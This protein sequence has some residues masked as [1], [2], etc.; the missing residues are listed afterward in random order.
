MRAL[1]P[2]LMACA[3]ARPTVEIRSDDAQSKIPQDASPPEI[4]LP[5]T[6]T[7]LRGPIEG[8][9]AIS[10]ARAPAGLPL[11]VAF[12]VRAK[13]P[14]EF[15]VGGDYRGGPWSLRHQIVVADEKGT[16]LFDAKKTPPL[17]LGGLMGP[18]KLAVDEER[19]EHFSVNSATDVLL[20]PGRYRV[21][22]VRRLTRQHLGAPAGPSGCDDLLPS[23]DTSTEKPACRAWLD[24]FPQI[25]SDVFIEITPYDREAIL[26]DIE[27]TIAT[28][29]DAGWDEMRNVRLGWFQWACRRLSCSCPALPDPMHP[30]DFMRE[31]AKSLPASAPA[32]PCKSATL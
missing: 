17:F 23:E 5:K 30:A 19:K 26:R 1:L 10:P 3:C 22:F 6:V 11:V 21:T 16:V 18:N 24:S 25:A 12:R 2:L 15:D 8:E 20:T 32:K 4:P 29:A 13:S 27:P 7:R 31:V 9:Y 14:L 28:S